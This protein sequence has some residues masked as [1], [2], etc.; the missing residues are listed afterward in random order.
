MEKLGGL[1][2]TSQRLNINKKT[3]SNYIYRNSIPLPT[4]SKLL[5]LCDEDLDVIPKECSLGVKR[6]HTAIPRIIKVN[7]S[8]MRLLGYYVSEGNA[9]YSKKSCYQVNFSCSETEIRDDL[10]QCIKDVFNVDLYKDRYSICISNRLIHY[11]FID[12]LNIG[13]NAKSKRIPSRFYVLP[14]HKMKEYPLRPL[15]F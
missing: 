10:T 8:L 3:F 13:K 12:I 5:V 14:K 11:F 6:D 9:R 1:K 15:V 4:I 7:G 2:H